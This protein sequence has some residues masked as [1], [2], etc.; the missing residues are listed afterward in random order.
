MQTWLHGVI[1]RT[2]EGA[3]EVQPSGSIAQRQPSRKRWC[4][5]DPSSIA[6]EHTLCRR[7]GA[8]NAL[9]ERED[10]LWRRQQQLWD[11]EAAAW[12]ADRAAWA[13]REAALVEENAALRAQLLQVPYAVTGGSGAGEPGDSTVLPLKAICCSLLACRRWS[14][15]LSGARSVSRYLGSWPGCSWAGVTLQMSTTL[16]SQT[17]YC[18][19]DVIMCL[20]QALAL[21]QQSATSAAPAQLR[22]PAAEGVP[23]PPAQDLQPPLEAGAGWRS[24]PSASSPYVPPSQ[25]TASRVSPPVSREEPLQQ[26]RANSSTPDILSAATDAPGGAPAWVSELQVECNMAFEASPYG[27]S[28]CAGLAPAI[29]S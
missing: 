2:Q 25:T 18:F 14:S 19:R 26:S 8:S 13:A 24:E 29:T 27:L 1:A 4:Y 6:A 17:A 21:A 20:A 28:A 10:E 16:Q 22:A 15:S 9:R 3:V 12:E 5:V 23:S 11:R 7:S